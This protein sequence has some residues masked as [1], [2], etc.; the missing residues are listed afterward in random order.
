MSAR[1]E[2]P[3]GSPEGLAARRREVKTTAEFQ[4][5]HAV[6]LRVTLERSE[7]Q[8]AQAV[9]LSAHTVRCLGSGFRR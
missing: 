3:E 6:W 1:A 4:R 8:I 2:F 7:E 5:V 9:G